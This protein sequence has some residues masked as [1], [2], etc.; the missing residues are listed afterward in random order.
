[1]EDSSLRWKQK[2]IDKSICSIYH[3]S[4]LQNQS[5]HNVREEVG[6]FTYIR[7]IKIRFD[8]RWEKIDLKRIA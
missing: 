5:N 8:W 4:Y 1:M 2:T 3:G 6:I 7:K